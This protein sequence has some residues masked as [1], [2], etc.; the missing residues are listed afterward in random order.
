MS[1]RVPCERE[2]GVRRMQ[3]NPRLNREHIDRIRSVAQLRSVRSG[4]VLYEPLVPMFL[5][6]LSWTEQSQSAEAVKMTRS[7]RFASEDNSQERCL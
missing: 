3:D 5:S 6:L 1:K 7:W 4:E 2:R